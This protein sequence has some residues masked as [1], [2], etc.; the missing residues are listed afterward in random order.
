MPRT[1]AKN[2]PYRRTAM[3]LQGGG[4]LG[5]YQVGVYEALH[6]AGQLPDWF[7]GTSIGAINAAIMAANRPEDRLDRLGRFWERISWPEVASVPD[8]SLLRRPYS[9]WN[10]TLAAWL[11]QPGFFHPRPFNPW[12]FPWDANT[13]SYYDT[14]D[15]RGTLEGLIDL[16][17]VNSGQV[18]LSM[19]AVDIITGQQVYFDSR[20]QEIRI[21]HILASSALPP[22]FAPVEIDGRWYWDGGIVSNTPLDV[23]IDDTPRASTL[24]FMIDVFN[25]L[26]AVPESMDDVAMRQKDITFATRS[27]RSIEAHRTIHNLRRAVNAMWEKLPPQEQ[28]DPHLKEL[29]KL[30][31]VTAMNIVHILYR[32]NG[33][34]TSC[35]DHDF[36]QS[37]IQARRAC[38]Y[39]DARAALADPHWLEPPP[40]DVG[41]IVHGP[42]QQEHPI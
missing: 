19:G 5:A 40:E 11:G 41:V 22:A 9:Q 12:L 21:N 3:V 36:S 33:T 42:S 39:A 34:E 10:G 15:L 1:D 4:A 13:A 17:I 14:S 24:V 20:K 26:G 37:S 25:N 27:G 7:A 32:G 18:R 6:E 16:D 28:K 2:T 31:C 35:K 30:R 8:D 29:A 23:V 38:G